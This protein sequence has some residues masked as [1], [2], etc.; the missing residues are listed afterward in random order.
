MCAMFFN[1]VNEESW[2][3]AKCSTFRPEGKMPFPR[4]TYGTRRITCLAICC[5]AAAARV[6]SATVELVDTTFE[7]T[8]APHIHYLKDESGTVMIDEVSTSEFEKVFVANGPDNP[9]FGVTSA[10]IWLRFSLVNHTNH[11]II[12]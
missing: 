9:N 4:P 3:L 11:S 2:G 10:S 7:Y 1:R 8:L 5:L 12:L 6:F